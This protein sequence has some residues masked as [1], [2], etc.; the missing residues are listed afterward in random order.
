MLTILNC[1]DYAACALCFMHRSYC[2]PFVPKIGIV[3][4]SELP[5]YCSVMAD[6]TKDALA[7]PLERMHHD[8]VSERRER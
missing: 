1:L 4:V 8:C 2:V 6:L 3:I 7:G 5:H